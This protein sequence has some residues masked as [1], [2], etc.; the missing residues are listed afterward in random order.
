MLALQCVYVLCALWLFIFV[1]P[2]RVR[3]LQASPANTTAI[4]VTW[5]HPVASG[6]VE[7]MLSYNISVIGGSFS[8][9][10]D[11]GTTM[12]I[13]TDLTP[14]SYYTIQVCVCVCVCVYVSI[15]IIFVHAFVCLYVHNVFI[16]L[17]YT[18]RMSG[19][20]FSKLEV[21]NVQYVVIGCL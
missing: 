18:D 6:T 9:I 21:Y 15:C 3:S 2:S 5:L 7:N 11:D 8:D 13:I 1:D 16:I 10:L 17:Y 20:N 4:K 14:G 12:Y 19:W